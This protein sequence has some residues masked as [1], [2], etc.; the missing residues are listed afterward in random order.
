M[1]LK[2]HRNSAVKVSGVLKAEGQNFLRPD[3]EPDLAIVW[4]Y[5]SARVM[6]SRGAGST[7]C[8]EALDTTAAVMMEKS[9][10][11][12]PYHPHN[13]PKLI[14]LLCFANTRLLLQ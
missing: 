5:R 3:N 14:Q 9:I 8:Q 2:Q 11:S 6:A 7:D 12:P 1:K 10:D 4:K 13:Y